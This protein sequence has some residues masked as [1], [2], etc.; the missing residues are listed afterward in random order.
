MAKM[1]LVLAIAAFALML[2][3]QPASARSLTTGDIYRGGAHW[4]NWS[5]AKTCTRWRD[6]GRKSYGLGCTG[7]NDMRSGCVAQR[8]GLR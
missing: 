1:R 2:S 3:V 4:C 7:P 5:I 6:H 8:K